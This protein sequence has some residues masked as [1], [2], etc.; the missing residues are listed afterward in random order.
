MIREHLHQLL[1]EDSQSLLIVA[2]LLCHKRAGCVVARLPREV[3]NFI[4]GWICTLPETYQPTA[5]QLSQGSSERRLINLER[6][7]TGRMIRMEDRMRQLDSKLDR[8][9]QLLTDK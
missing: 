3:V 1:A 7:L 2:L 9:L 4:C 6:V 8:V 5:A